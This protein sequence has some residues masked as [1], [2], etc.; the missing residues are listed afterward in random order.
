[1][2]ESPCGQGLGDVIDDESEADGEQRWYTRDESLL[3]P[4]AGQLV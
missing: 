1:M 2:F 4:A 3:Y